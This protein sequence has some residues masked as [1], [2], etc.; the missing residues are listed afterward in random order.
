MRITCQI[1]TRNRC[2]E[3]YGMLASLHQQDFKDWDL[4]ILDES[5][6]PSINYKYVYDLITRMKHEGHGVKFLSNQL[7][8][9]ISNAR[10]LALKEDNWNEWAVRIDDD[11]IIDKNY[12][13]K[14][15]AV[16]EDKLKKG[17]KVGAVGGVVPPLGAPQIYRNSKK[18]KVFNEI[19]F[20][21][22]SENSITVQIDDDGGY[23]Y[24]PGKVI[25]SHHLRSS[26]LFNVKAAR[27]INGFPLDQG[28]MIGWR[29]ETKFSMKLVWAGYKLFTDTSAVCWHQRSNSGGG[30]MSNYAEYVSLQ[31]AHFQKWA[32]RQYKKNKKKYGVD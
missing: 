20:I 5:E 25:P 21:E 30:R 10:N 14:L 17:I 13:S 1:A 16:A 12:L 23:S 6:T 11:S 22:S 28:G 26:F 9:G 3:L 27:E 8:K 18:I 7:R 15:V 24:H 19:K 29:E 4:I 32:S 31:E 2:G